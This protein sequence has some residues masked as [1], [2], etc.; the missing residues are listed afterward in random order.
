VI[1]VPFCH[2]AHSSFHRISISLGRWLPASLPSLSFLSFFLKMVDNALFF[3]SLIIKTSLPFPALRLRSLLPLSEGATRLDDR[4]G[5][6]F[7]RIV[8]SLPTFLTGF[9]VLSLVTLSALA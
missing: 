8:D 9:T 3:L 5:T 2:V 6:S 1:P 7:L 4:S